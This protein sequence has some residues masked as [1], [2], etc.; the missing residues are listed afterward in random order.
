MEILANDNVSNGKT[1]LVH[2]NLLEG[3]IGAHETVVR[4]QIWSDFVSE[5]YYKL[6]SLKGLDTN[7][8]LPEYQQQTK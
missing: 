1:N 3:K 6:M 8:H 4:T 5:A 2:L 7:K